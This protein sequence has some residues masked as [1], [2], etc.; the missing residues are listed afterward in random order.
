MLMMRK[1][2]H[3]AAL[4]KKEHTTNN[5]LKISLIDFCYLCL[6]LTKTQS[7]FTLIITSGIQG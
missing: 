2:A 4:W 7:P 1:G 5:Y 3:T 6:N